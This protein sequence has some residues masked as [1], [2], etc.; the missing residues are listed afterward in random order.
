MPTKISRSSTP[1][2]NGVDVTRSLAIMLAMLSHAL[3]EF[4]VFQIWQG[5]AATVTRFAMQT[6]PVTFIGLFGAMLEI[7]YAPRFANGGAAAATRQL[8]TRALQCYLLYAL[9]V[10][11][12]HVS[13]EQ[14][15]GYTIRCLLMLGITPYADILKF[16]AL[17]L[18]AA[19]LLLRLRMRHGLKAILLFAV[20]VPAAYPLL[21]Q[22][23]EPPLLLGRDYLLKPASFLYGGTNEA[24]GPSVLHGLALV[25][26]GMLLGRGVR[27]LLSSDVRERRRGGVILG[28]MLGTTAAASAL[29]WNWHAPFETVAAIADMSLRNDNHPIYATIGL[30]ATLLEVLLAILL[31]DRLGRRWGSPLLFLG[32]TSLF[33]F[34]FGNILLYLAPERVPVI[35]GG[36]PLALVVFA[37][38]MGQSWLFL[39][40]MTPVA[41]DASRIWRAVATRFQR[42]VRWM[43]RPVDGTVSRLVPSRG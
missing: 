35:G 7:V 22:I 18:L 14:S 3:I 25:A 23:P 33:T 31:F 11:A 29:M 41:A 36:L 2:I 40:L 34:A 30:T 15:L 8:W 10:F 12:L 19:P 37:I 27:L 21:S 20:A 16:Y 26:A 5:T 24:G 1:R 38:M 4:D 9:T 43:Q 42:L 32:R 17:A 13:G 6:A 28:L 39:R